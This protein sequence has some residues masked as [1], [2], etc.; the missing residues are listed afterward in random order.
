[1]NTLVSK[2]KG[3]TLKFEPP[4]KFI[5]TPLDGHC[6]QSNNSTGVI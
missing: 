6:D 1:M 4:W 5:F 2:T 3:T